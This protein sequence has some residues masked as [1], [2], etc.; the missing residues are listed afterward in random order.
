MNLNESDY[1]FASAGFESIYP[2]VEL[3]L[4]F[5]KTKVALYTTGFKFLWNYLVFRI[6]TSWIEFSL[7]PLHPQL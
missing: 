3:G 7:K 4:G 1:P 2:A 6:G 5:A